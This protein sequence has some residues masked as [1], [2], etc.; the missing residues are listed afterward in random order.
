MAPKHVPPAIHLKAFNCPRCGAL[1]DQH[2]YKG[3]VDTL[4]KDGPTPT[5]FRLDKVK[6]LEKSGDFAND[7]S[8]SE[9][10]KLF[11]KWRSRSDGNLRLEE[12]SQSDSYRLVVQNLHI[13]RCF[14]CNEISL[15]KYDSLLFPSAAAEFE[16]NEDLAKDIRDD[17]DE[18]QAVLNFSPRSAAALLRLCIQKIC[19]QLELPG[20]NINEDIATLVSRGLR[21]EIQRALDIVRVVGNEAVHPGTIDLRDNRETASKLFGLVNRIASDMITHPKEI[22]A[23][24]ETLPVEKLRAIEQR[25][26]KK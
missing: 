8:T 10:E 1:A 26:A 5:I 9:R 11:A 14:S 13:S 4:G 16:A 7:L 24:Y 25:D 6:E 3:C 19:L 20:K 23:M 22:A 21:P 15:W 12:L 18:A 17:F 2:W